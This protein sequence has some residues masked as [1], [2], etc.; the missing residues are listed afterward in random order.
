MKN[1]LFIPF[2]NA[3][4]VHVAASDANITLMAELADGWLPMERTPAEYAPLVQRIFSRLPEFGRSAEDFTIRARLSALPDAAGKPSLDASLA[5]VP[6]MLAAGVTQIT[7]VPQSF[8]GD[9]AGL[10]QLMRRVAKE[11]E[12]Y[13]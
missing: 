3:Y 7:V 1:Y 6:D 12:R 2:G 13:R 5:A 11:A 9:V 4:L 8:T 10:R